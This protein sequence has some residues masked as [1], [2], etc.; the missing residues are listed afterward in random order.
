M[1]GDLLLLN[2]NN[3]ILFIIKQRKKINLFSVGRKE[4]SKLEEI[5]DMDTLN[6]LMY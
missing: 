5:P 3:T 2:A 6:S 4:H 1:G